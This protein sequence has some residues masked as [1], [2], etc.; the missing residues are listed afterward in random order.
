MTDNAAVPESATAAST[1]PARI[2]AENPL[3]LLD[4]DAGR[5]ARREAEGR[6]LVVK[7][8]GQVFELPPEIPMEVL[9]PLRLLDGSVALLATTDDPQRMFA[10]LMASRPGI[11]NESIRALDRA[12]RILFGEVSEELILDTEAENPDDRPGPGDEALGAGKYRRILDPGGWPTFMAQRPSLPDV[13]Q[14]GRGLLAG[15]GVSLG[16]AFGSPAPSENGGPP[17]RQT[18][19]G[20]TR[21]TPVR[22][23][24]PKGR[25]AG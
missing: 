15:Y 8:R 21:S 10:N 14:L 5:A 23:G 24:S 1:P 2:A 12:A 19:S 6:P 20:S 4:L 16:E 17:S 11:V 3:D 22:R 9:A 25:R 18:S 7:L 13:L